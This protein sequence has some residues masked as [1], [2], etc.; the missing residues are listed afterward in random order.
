[1]KRT[2]IIVSATLMLAACGEQAQTMGGVKSDAPA[3]TGTGKAY[4]LSNWKQG[5]KTSWESE[6]KARAQG[7]QNEYNR[8]N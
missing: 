4:A 2:L 5:D 7:S 8:I 1:M 3:Y 6:L